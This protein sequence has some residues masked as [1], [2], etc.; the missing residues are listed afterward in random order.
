MDTPAEAEIKPAPPV[1]AAKTAGKTLHFLGG[2]P[3]SGS[4]LLANLLFQNPRFH[5]TATSGVLSLLNGVRLQWEKVSEFKAMPKEEA[6]AAKVRVL[7]GM[8]LA[9]FAN[10]D[11][12]VIFDK[13][14]GW[15]GAIPFIEAVLG[16][17]VK[18]LMAVRDVRDVLAS[19]EKITSKNPMQP[20][21][22]E[23]G[24]GALWGTIEGRCQIWFAQNQ[25]VGS[26]YRKINDALVKGFH[27]RMHF[28][29]YEDLTNHPARTMRGVY[30]F[31]G[32]EYFEHD[33]KNVEQVTT[34]DDDVWKMPGLHV[35][36]KEVKPQ[37]SQWA[38]ILPANV[39]KKYPGKELWKRKK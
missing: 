30:E 31:L 11:R 26:A 4:T 16:R 28:V 18:L 23:M 1:S 39:A 34:E 29:D 32:E 36:R 22:Q 25:P 12:P 3:R 2:L 6:Q 8:V 21:G 14:R 27:D 35:I 20:T 15:V 33:F 37:P 10:V 7:R 5:V 13:S 17:K 24:N 19:F 38:K 9:Y